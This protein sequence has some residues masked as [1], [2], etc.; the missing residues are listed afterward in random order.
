VTPSI[1]DILREFAEFRGT[2]VERAEWLRT[3]LADFTE[4]AGA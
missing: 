3:R 1:D 4:P 2:G